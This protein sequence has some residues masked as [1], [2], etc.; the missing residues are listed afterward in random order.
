MKKEKLL[1]NTIIFI[2]LFKKILINIL[3]EYFMKINK[4]LP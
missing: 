3:Y 1:F 4:E 2:Y